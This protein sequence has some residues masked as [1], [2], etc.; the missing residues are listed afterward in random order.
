M[1]INID[2]VFPQIGVCRGSY[3]QQGSV[4]CDFGGVC[5]LVPGYHCAC[6]A[7]GWGAMFGSIL[8]CSIFGVEKTVSFLLFGVYALGKFGGSKVLILPML[9]TL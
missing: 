6:L 2:L 3:F 1:E 9:K 7:S 8:R 5:G 4:V